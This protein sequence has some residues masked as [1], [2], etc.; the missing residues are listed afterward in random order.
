MKN[1]QELSLVFTYTGRRI[2]YADIPA[3][4]PQSLQNITVLR[5]TELVDLLEIVNVP[6][7]AF[8]VTTDTY[9]HLGIFRYD[10][11]LVSK[12]KPIANKHQ[13]ILLKKG[14]EGSI[15]SAA[16]YQDELDFVGSLTAVIRYFRSPRDIKISFLRRPELAVVSPDESQF[17]NLGTFIWNHYLDNVLMR[18]KGDSMQDKG[19]QT[20]DI[21]LLNK[22]IEDYGG[23][24]VAADGM[25]GLTLKKLEYRI[26]E[27]HCKSTR[28]VPANAKYAVK[29]VD[30]YSGEAKVFGVATALIR[31][32]RNWS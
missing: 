18:V 8:Q 19:I 13:Y 3:G 28:L 22:A 5:E 14:E 23:D 15:I 25:S 17:Y 21:V 26:A 16:E 9:E 30:I 10:F 31:I 29:E 24:I 20:K 4:S 32:Y 12:Q 11:I 6:Q 1:F 27:T 7:D 2:I